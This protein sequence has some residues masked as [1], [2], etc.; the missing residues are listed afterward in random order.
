MLED[1]QKQAGQ[2]VRTISDENLL[3]FASTVIFTTEQYPSTNDDWEDRSK[4]QKTWVDW[5]TSYKRSH[6]KARVKSQAAE[7]S[8]KFGAANAAEKVLT[9]SKVE[10]NNGG[11]KV[12]MK[13]LGG[14]FYNLSAAVINEKLVLEQLVANNAK[15]AVTNKDLVTIVKKFQRY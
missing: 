3:L 11:N 9:T 1:T 8:D 6:A 10:K 13:A 14:Y 7:G 12:G 2:A 4:E 5:K 15:L